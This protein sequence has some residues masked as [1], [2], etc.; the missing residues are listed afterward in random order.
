MGLTQAVNLDFVL[1]I[2]INVIFVQKTVIYNLL[3]LINKTNT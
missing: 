3:D 2:S 1:D